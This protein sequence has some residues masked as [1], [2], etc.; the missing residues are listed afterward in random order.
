MKQ[1]KI[2]IYGKH[3]V[4]EALS[5][6]PGA[7]DKIFLAKEEENE[8]LIAVARHAG[9]SVASLGS[10][11]SPDRALGSASHQ[12]VIGRVLLDRLI[13]PY[14]N[15]IHDLEIDSDTS[16]VLLGEVQDPHN[17]GAII[18]SAAAFGVSGVLIPKHNQAPITGVVV[19]VS[20]GMAFRIPIIEIGNVNTA[21]RELKDLGFWIYGL[22]GQ[23]KKRVTEE[24]YDRPTVFVLGNEAEGLR[25]KTAEMCDVLIS[26]PTH[27]RCESLNVAA[28]GA[29][30]FFAWSLQHPAALNE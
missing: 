25:Q 7:L 4:M 26:I 30:T 22:D 19:K 29:V 16:L 5:H 18:R 24:P 17:V 10:E 3:A 1:N 28:S 2:Y 13:K 20:A 11:K 15:F 12:G 23:A 27:P 9:V 8:A 21:I 14:G 6:A